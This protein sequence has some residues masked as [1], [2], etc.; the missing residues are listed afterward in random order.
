MSKKDRK[1]VRVPVADKPAAVRRRETTSIVIR[2]LSTR[3]RINLKRYKL[4]Q[5]RPRR[6]GRVG[7][8]GQYWDL[9][10]LL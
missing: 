5:K 4:G 2:G 10:G 3:K 7:E 6:S 9:A 1:G 8:K